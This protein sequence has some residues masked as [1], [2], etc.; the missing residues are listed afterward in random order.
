MELTTGLSCKALDFNWPTGKA[1]G[2]PVLQSV[3]ASFPPGSISLVAGET[4]AGKST[5]LHLL[6]GLLRPTAGEIWADGKPVS[7]WP[8]HHRTRWRQQVGM[9]FQHLALVPDLSVAENLLLP[10]IPRKMTWSGMQTAID[11]QLTAAELSALA[12]LPAK[13]LSGGQRQR[14]A[15]ARALVGRPRFILADEPT[16]FQDDRHTTRITDQLAKAAHQGA[17]VVICSHDLR[18]RNTNGID[19]RLH[20]HAAS[21]TRAAA[22][23]APP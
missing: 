22:R 1:G 6:A 14:L 10:L 16:A 20:L 11:R 5:L 23:Q 17:V 13:S 15:I 3:E 2:P 7:R 9:V 19:Q 8:T 18:L 21:L 12:G 4:G